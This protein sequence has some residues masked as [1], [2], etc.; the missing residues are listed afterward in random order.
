MFDFTATVP[1]PTPAPADN[2]SHVIVWTPK[3]KAKKDDVDKNMDLGS[4]DISDFDEIEHKQAEDKQMPKK[5][6]D[7]NRITRT[8]TGSKG[9]AADFRMNFFFSSQDQTKEGEQISPW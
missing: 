1:S 6:F 5:G 4:L 2:D 9:E 3:S 8:S 7:L